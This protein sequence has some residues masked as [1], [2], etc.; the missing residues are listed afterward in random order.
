MHSLINLLRYSHL[1][2]QLLPGSVNGTAQADGGSSNGGS[3]RVSVDLAAADAAAAAAA[4]AAGGASST[5]AQAPESLLSDEGFELL[6]NTT[7]LDYLTHLVFRL[8]ENKS[9]TADHP[10]RFRIEVMFCPGAAYD[11]TQVGTAEQRAV[12]MLLCTAL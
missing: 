3:V 2:H 10:E 4:A 9:V 1:R 12:L 6:R 8:Y 5:A 11:P 7:E